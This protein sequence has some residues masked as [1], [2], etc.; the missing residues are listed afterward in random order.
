VKQN[1]YRS[2]EIAASETQYANLSFRLGVPKLYTIYSFGKPAGPSTRWMYGAGLG[3]QIGLSERSMLNIEAISHQEIWI[4]NSDAPW[5][6]YSSRFNMHHQLRL[7]YARDLGFA[8]VFV[9][10]TLNLT[11]AHSHPADDIYIPYNPIQ[12][13]WAFYDVT[14]D[15][16][17]ETNIAFWAGIRGG[18]RF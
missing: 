2:F 4:G 18:I 7:A 16:Y 5:F 13:D 6:V 3:T 15:N 11:T 10:P 9:G 17:H 14:Y 12:P 1:G 8:D